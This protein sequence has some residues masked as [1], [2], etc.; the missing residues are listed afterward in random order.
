MSNEDT[1]LK[2]LEH[3]HHSQKLTAGFD[4]QQF[5]TAPGIKEACVLLV[6]QI[7]EAVTKLDAPFMARHNKIPWQAMRDMRHRLVH[8]YEHTDF[9][10]VWN[11]IQEDVPELV[12]AL[13]KIVGGAA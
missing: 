11:T 13:K 1:L 7:G 3:C 12:D 2:M 4:Y 9:E 10:I 5:V 8:D 6:Q